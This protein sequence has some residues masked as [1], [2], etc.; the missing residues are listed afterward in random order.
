MEKGAYLKVGKSIDEQM[1]ATD[2]LGSAT[3]TARRDRLSLSAKVEAEVA[4]SI[5]IAN[6][7]HH[8]PN[9]PEDRKK[10]PSFH[11]VTK[12]IAEEATEVFVTRIG[13]E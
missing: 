7:L 8:T 13:E 10:Q 4:A 5:T 12:D 11:I 6:I 2:V 9:Q 1:V 3:N